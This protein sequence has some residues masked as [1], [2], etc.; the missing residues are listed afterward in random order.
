MAVRR[1]LLDPRDMLTFASEALKYSQQ[2]PGSLR[3]RDLFRAYRR[4]LR[5]QRTTAF[6]LADPIP[7]LP[8]SAIEMLERILKADARVFEYG[9]GGSTLFF[10]RRAQQ[11]FAVEHD[12]DWWAET[13]RALAE[14]DF[15]NA[16][17]KL[18]EPESGSISA[19]ADAADPS[20]YI[21][22]DKRFAGQ[23]WKA[24]ASA[25]DAF[26]AN[27]FDLVIVDGRARPS[28]FRHAVSKVRL[29]GYLILDNAERTH[30]GSIHSEM[31]RAGWQ[32]WHCHGPV[33]FIPQFSQ[34]VF[35][36]RPAGDRL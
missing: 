26:P 8:F 14:R 12:R 29:G 28:C 36:R 31:K 1:T 19:S 4:W 20:A 35:W 7:W 17:V 10:A 11:V 24:Y 5:T 9:V 23:S 32:A 16:E 30:Y 15:R 25:I 6:S 18:I 3:I 33:P 13:T 22:S 2:H 34:T 27:Y 21:S